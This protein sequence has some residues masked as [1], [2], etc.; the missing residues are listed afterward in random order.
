MSQV[1]KD[2]LG[3]YARAWQRYGDYVRL[4][5]IP[6][7]YAYLLVHPEAVEHVLQ[8]NHK[9]YRK[10]DVLLRPMRLLVGDGLFTSE[11]DA[12]LRQR[13]LD[14]PAFHR[15]QLT[16]LSPLMLSAAEGFLRKREAAGRGQPL[17][18][19][20]EMMRLSLRI[21]GTTLFSTDVTGDADATGQAY[22]TAFAYVSHRMNS[23]QLTPSWWPSSRNRSFARAK[24]LLDRVVLGLIDD[25]RRSGSRPDD[26]LSLLLAAQDEETGAGMTDQQVKDEALTLLTAGHETVG[27]ALSWSWYLLGK[28]PQVQNDLYD[29]VRGRLQGRSPTIDDLPHL[30]LARAVFEESMRLYPPA[31]G[32]PRETLAADEVGGFPIPAK[33]TVILCQY[34]THRHPAIWDEPERFNPARFLPPQPAGRHKFTYF[35]FGAGPRACIGN[36]FALIEGPLVLAT[37]A[38]R[39]RIEL[40]PGQAVVPDPTF[41]LRPRDGVK[42]TL[43]PR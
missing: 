42:V 43:W 36:T 32:L 1:R 6:G 7:V 27:A 9:N 40:V 16:K 5:F 35:P 18:I 39:L 34:L 23:L 14:Q 38:Q 13:R 4:R 21:A 31:W 41:T 3:L 22:R 15:Q 29:E 26:L 30:P 20:D 37:V 24:A 10:P 2:P 11:G 12:W 28:H 25:R 33:A 8:K 19:L 17:D